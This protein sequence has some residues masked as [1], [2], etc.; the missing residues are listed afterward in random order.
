MFKQTKLKIMTRYRE[1]GDIVC[2]M[3]YVLLCYIWTLPTNI[4]NYLLI[5]KFS[6]NKGATSVG[7]T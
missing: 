3:L 2:Y 5:I 6:T 7:H 4:Q 1:E